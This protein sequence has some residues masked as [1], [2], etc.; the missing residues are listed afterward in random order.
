MGQPKGK[1]AQEAVQWQQQDTS[2][3]LEVLGIIPGVNSRTVIL[4]GL[5]SS[6]LESGVSCLKAFLASGSTRFGEASRFLVT[7]AFA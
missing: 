2:N 3:S 7:G 6:S 4:A 5:W 1:A